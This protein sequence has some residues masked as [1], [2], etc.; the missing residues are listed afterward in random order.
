MVSKTDLILVTGGAGFIGSNAANTLAEN[1]YKVVISDWFGEDQRWKNIA[2]AVIHDLVRPEDLSA[3]MRANGDQLG[4]IVH[5][6]AI[7]ATTEQDV[8]KIIENNIRL[9]L[10]LWDYACREDVAF[11]YASSAATYGDGTAGFVDDDSVAGLAN[12]APLNPYGWSKHLVDRRIAADVV[13]GRKTPSVWAGLKFFNVFGPRE[14][15]K[16]GMR[17][18][19]HQ[20]WPLA[21]QGET[22]RLF[23]SDNPDYADGGQL[24]DFIHVDDCV[25][26]IRT[27]L[28]QQSLG[29]VFNVGTGQARSFEDLALATFKAVGRDPKIEYMEMPDKLRGRYHYYTHADTTRLKAHQLA[30]NFK[31]LEDGVGNYIDWLRANPDF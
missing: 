30:P 22:V 13:A 23:K 14:S 11:V 28:A 5:M 24:R 3:W 17:S 19:I 20:I 7:S 21:A 31:S 2:P 26:V 29:G 9:S 18:V 6:G 8:D 12:L 16:G 25:H 4:G 15:H 10:D 27:A 1:G